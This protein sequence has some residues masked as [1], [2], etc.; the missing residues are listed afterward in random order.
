MPVIQI[1]VHNQ[2][3]KGVQKGRHLL[4]SNTKLIMKKAMNH[5]FNFQEYLIRIL[6][7]IMIMGC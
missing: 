4:Q 6:N 1:S 2:D 7:Y 5:A 3:R